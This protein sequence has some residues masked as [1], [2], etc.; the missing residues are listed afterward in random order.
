MARVLHPALP[1]DAGHAIWKRDFTGACGLF[2]VVLKPCSQKAVHAFLD[3][4]K[5]FGL[6]FSWGGYESLALNCDPQLGARSIPVD[7]EGPLL[8]FHIGLE[9]IEDLKA[10]LRRG[11]EA[12]NAAKA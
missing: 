5:L 11:F 3:S 9:G 6:G 8:R 4:L 2:G 7:L 10:D 1:G 12:L